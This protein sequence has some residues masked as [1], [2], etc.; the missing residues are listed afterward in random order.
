MGLGKTLQSL[1]LILSNPAPPGW[2]AA[3]PDPRPVEDPCPIRT[4]LLVMPTNLISQWQEEIELHV[5]PR[6]LKW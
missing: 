2:A 1:M 5:K 4:T 6:A 3:K